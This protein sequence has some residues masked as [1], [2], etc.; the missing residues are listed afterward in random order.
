MRNI[1]IYEQ[2]T[3]P[4]KTY[5]SYV[6]MEGVRNFNSEITL[7]NYG[8]TLINYGITLIN[9]G[10]TLINYGITLVIPLQCYVSL[11]FEHLYVNLVQLKETC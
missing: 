11:S 10:L 1:E 5:T 3:K 4:M 6:K 8:I 7:I 2:T 9:Y